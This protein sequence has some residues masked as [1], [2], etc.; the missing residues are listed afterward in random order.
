MIAEAMWF[1]K[2]SS[3]GGDVDRGK[4]RDDVAE[5]LRCLRAPRAN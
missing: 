2:P 4:M 3:D 1:V 5:L